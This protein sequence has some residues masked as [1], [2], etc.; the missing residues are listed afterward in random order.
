MIRLCR[1]TRYK[2]GTDEK[3]LINH[4]VASEGS[5]SEAKIDLSIALSEAKGSEKETGLTFFSSE[6][7]SLEAEIDQSITLSETRGS[8]E[9]IHQT[10]V[11]SEARGS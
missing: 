1:A 7:K 2:T 5:G 11:S 4:F 9:K 3:R 8:D 6:A 10:F